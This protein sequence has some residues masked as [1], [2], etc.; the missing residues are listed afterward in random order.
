M[1]D[2][3][4]EKKKSTVRGSED[5]SSLPPLSSVVDHLF[6][7]KPRDAK[8]ATIEL[9]LSKPFVLGE[10]HDQNS[11]REFLFKMMPHLRNMGFK[12]FY[13]E[14]LCDGRMAEMQFSLCKNWYRLIIHLLGEHIPMTFHQRSLIPNK[15][16]MYKLSS[17]Q[18]LMWRRNLVSVLQK[19]VKTKTIRRR[20]VW[21]NPKSNLPLSPTILHKPICGILIKRLVSQSGYFS[22]YP[23]NDNWYCASDGSEIVNFFQ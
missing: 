8:T 19:L 17:N 4:D 12:C 9:D 13:M 7:T 10:D 23:V 15:G 21:V 14:F 5:R 20:K 1:D 3:K 6:N 11:A 16:L 18:D 22:F 2:K